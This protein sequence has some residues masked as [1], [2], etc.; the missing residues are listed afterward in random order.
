MNKTPLLALVVIT[1]MLPS[2]F[3]AISTGYRHT[4]DYYAVTYDG[5][6]DA[7]VS[8][9]LNIRNTQ[10][11]TIDVLTFELPRDIVIY[12]VAQQ[13]SGCLQYLQEPLCDQWDNGYCISYMTQE[14]CASWGSGSYERIDTEYL[15]EETLS[16][17][18]LLKITLPYE[19]EPDE[20]AG[21]IISYKVNRD[22]WRFIN[23]HFD[24]ETIVDNNAALIENVRVSVDVQPGLH[25][26]GKDAEVEYR[27][28]LFGMQKAA[29]E[30]SL[31]SAQYSRYTSVIRQSRGFVRTSSN[32]DAGESFHVKGGYGKSRLALYAGT[33]FWW[34]AGILG[35]ILL[36]VNVLKRKRQ[37]EGKR[38]VYREQ[39]RLRTVVISIATGFGAAVV[40]AIVSVLG[41]ILLQVLAKVYYHDFQ[42]LVMPLAILILLASALFLLFWP[43]IYIGRRYDVVDGFIT[44][45]A[46]LASLILIVVCLVIAA[47]L[48]QPIVVY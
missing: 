24:F 20:T 27:Q 15:D 46:T 41:I 7:I 30:Q 33:V 1:L 8:A 10:D 16:D 14:R 26:R 42:L 25:L 47:M 48:F 34:I 40:L 21:I 43:A 3:A 19:I 4:N 31:D 36:V 44:F 45:G 32:L 29:S 5:E 2:A 6:G 12:E 17:R 22:A 39:S 37:G 28:E 35:T 13:G 23:Y 9:N 11:K 18:T 38:S